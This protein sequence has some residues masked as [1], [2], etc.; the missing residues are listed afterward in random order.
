MAQFSKA[1]QKLARIEHIQEPQKLAIARENSIALYCAKQH[2]IERKIEQL[3]SHIFGQEE[4]MNILKLYDANLP[5]IKI[6]LS[7]LS[8]NKQ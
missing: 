7:R 6:I 3:Q 8:V 2:L 5:K 4:K 1:Q